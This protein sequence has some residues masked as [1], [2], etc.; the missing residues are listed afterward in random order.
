MNQTISWTANRSLR[1]L[2]SSACLA[3]L[4]ALA[5]C[6]QAADAPPTAPVVA[7][8]G[9]ICGFDQPFQYSFLAWKDKIKV[10]QGRAVLHG[11]ETKG[12]AGVTAAMN[13]AAQADC[14][15]ALRLRTKP[16]NTAKTL[17]FRLVNGDDALAAWNFAL[18]APA[19]AFSVVLPANAA[20]LARPDKVES[21]SGAAFDLARVSGWQ[22]L[23]DWQPGVLDVEIEAVLAVAPDPAMLAQRQAAAQ[24][25]AEQARKDADKAAAAAQ[26]QTAEREELVRRYATRGPASPE[27]VAVTTVAPDVIELEIEAQ[28]VVPSRFGRYEAQP[29]D[30]KRL[31]KQRSDRAFPMAKLIRDGHE[32]GWLQGKDLDWFESFEELAGDPLLEFLAEDPAGYAISSADDPAFA[33]ARAPVAVYRK[34]KP[35]DWQQLMNR[36]P[37]CHRLYLKLD[38][39]LKPGA[40]YTVAIAKLNVKN[41][42]A[43]LAY[44]SRKLRSE[45][46]HADQIGFRPDDPGK[47]AFLSLWMGSGGGLA[48]PAGL[49][50][51]VIDEASGKDV[52]TGPV[53]LALAADGRELLA[54]KQVP[55]SSRTAIWRMDF[56]ALTTPGRYRVHVEGIGCSYP[57]EIGPDVWRKAFLVQMRGLYHERA[58]TE[59]GEPW[60][61]FRKPRDF[62]P[63]DG[64]LVTRT[65]YDALSHGDQAFALIAKGDTG[66]KVADAWGG[67]HDAGDWNPRR[68]SHMS[69][70]LAQLELVE[71]Y[72][73]FFNALALRIPRTEGLPDIITE[74]L[75]E[76]DCFRRLQHPDG[77][78]PFGLETNGDPL[79]GEVSFLSAQHVFELAPNMRDSW[80][81]AAVAGRAAKVL[82]PLKPELAAVYQD[83]AIRAFVWAETDYARRKAEGSL[84]KCK[85]LWTAIDNRNLAALVLFDLTGEKK[86]HDLFL[87]NTRLTAADHEVVWYGKWSQTDAAFLYAR[88]DDAKADPQLKRNALAA[89]LKQ[90]DKSLDFAAGN[91]FNVTNKD[92]WRPLFGGFYSTAGGTETARAHYLTG[93]EKYLTGT[94][95]S[96]LFQSGCNPNNLV[97]TSGLGANPVRHPLQVDARST[98]QAAP[99][100]LTVFGNVDYWQWKGGFWDWPIAFINKPGT[101]WPDAYAWPLTEAF[102]DIH[103]Y[104]SMDEFVIDTWT[105]NVFVWGYLA[106]RGTK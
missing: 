58:G 38:H 61:T 35:S 92:R 106:A 53:E 77:G 91:A 65:A 71:M 49:R 4:L 37:A 84:E 32:L 52:F 14:S 36:Y 57:F 16:G 18:P 33:Q 79:P 76:I 2:R 86:W 87:E 95:R 30:K 48:Y 44:D 59:L 93:D 102:F 24:A 90:A 80:Y 103:L 70:T 20:P 28:R 13:L 34:S 22:L 21:K 41:P 25:V 89:V 94:V 31:E 8:D 12:G 55:N 27:V 11:L 42:Q 23:G 46:V 50:F 5:A 98:G 69:V 68:V 72:P 75:F 85:E 99:A 83:S 10:E 63:A 64:T 47:R 19:E 29:G 26:R 7:K 96:C 1:N 81:Y 45:A 97:Y 78:I 101:L 15:P 100:G 6:G 82:R 39:A 62:H 60:T 54:G 105:P 56:G 17:S 74:A 43:T 51:A 9:R 40:S 3:G 104:V 67:Y 88:L 73:A 66:E